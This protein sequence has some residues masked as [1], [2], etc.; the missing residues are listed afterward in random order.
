MALLKHGGV[1]LDTDVLSLR[2]MKPLRQASGRSDKACTVV[3]EEPGGLGNSLIAATP[4][5][6]FLRLWWQNYTD[7][8]DKQWGEHSIIRPGRIAKDHPDL[9][10]IMP[11]KTF[12][13]FYPGNGHSGRN[14]PKLFKDKAKEAAADMP[15][16]SA[17]LFSN[18]SFLQG[19]QR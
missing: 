18:P 3:G 17:L 19:Q 9:I 2:D 5:C 15:G 4:N 6:Q 7:F 10:K 8:D 12:T 1:Y 16:I 14:A 13:P 11:T